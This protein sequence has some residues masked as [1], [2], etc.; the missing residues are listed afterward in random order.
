MKLK[1]LLLLI[2][3]GG[4][5]FGSDGVGTDIIPRT[6]NFIIFIAIIYYLLADFIK[7]FFKK[8]RD[9]I[10]SKLNSVQTKVKESKKRREEAALKIKDAERVAEE[11]ISTSKKEALIISENYDKSLKFDLE[12]LDK[13]HKEQIELESRKMKKVVVNETLKEM[14]EDDGVA[15]NEKEFVNIILKRVS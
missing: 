7:N 12:I 9:E 6:V 15:I 13:Q 3:S 11:I 8:R 5:L 4:T 10:A 2:V 14:F 1:W